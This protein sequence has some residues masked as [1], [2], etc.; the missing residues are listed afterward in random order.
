M[1]H[2]STAG[3]RLLRPVVALAVLVAIAGCSY[4]CITFYTLDGPS[5]EQGRERASELLAALGGYREA[6]GRYP[7]AIE[8]L[9]PEYLTSTP[10][11]AWRYEYTY[12]AC[13]DGTGYILFFPLRGSSDDWCGY[14]S[15]AGEWKCTDSI[16]PYFYDRPCI[17]DTD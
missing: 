2:G 17:S 14:S 13:S 8:A 12:I 3:R 10:R 16:P 6:K 9:V 5:L 15:G 11:P 1:K 4:L 7:A